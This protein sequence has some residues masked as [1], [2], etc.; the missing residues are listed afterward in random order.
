MANAPNKIIGDFT[1]P[2]P[3]RESHYGREQIPNRRYLSEDLNIRK[4]FKAFF[5][6]QL[7][8]KNPQCLDRDLMKFFRKNLL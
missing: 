6:N 5:K 2:M 7:D 4:L 1:E 3:S 8:T